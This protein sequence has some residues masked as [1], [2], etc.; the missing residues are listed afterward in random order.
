M[1]EYFTGGF[2]STLPFWVEFISTFVILFPV[3]DVVSIYPLNSITMASN[4]M[5]AFY[6]DRID[7]AEK[8]KFIVRFFRT[9]CTVPPL[10]CALFV[11]DNLDIVLSYAG[12][13]AIPI[14]MII[15][16]YLNYISQKKVIEELDF[17]SPKTHLTGV[18]S[19]PSALFCIMAI[20]SILFAYI[21][22]LCT[23]QLFASA[24]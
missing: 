1:W 4:V 17:P 20:G 16:P 11:G 24:E 12:S 2:S 15:P 7:K 5:A 21:L 23:L 9:I 13:C 8:D 22:V 19:S 10:L 3:M 14:A 18:F 6:H